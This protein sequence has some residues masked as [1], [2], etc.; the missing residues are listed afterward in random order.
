MKN[1]SNVLTIAARAFPAT[2]KAQ[3]A[4][5]GVSNILIV[6]DDQSVLEL[7]ALQL[8]SH[9][10]STIKCTSAQS[11]LDLFKQ[12]QVDLLIADVTLADGSGVE[13]GVRLQVLA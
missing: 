12:I 4:P 10:H 13:T 9:G 11:A 2:E 5:P 6:D 7:T 1:S 8:R 3:P